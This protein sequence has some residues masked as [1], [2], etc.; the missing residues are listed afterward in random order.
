[1]KI[2]RGEKIGVVLSKTETQLFDKGNGQ[3]LRR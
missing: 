3:S 1:V 2:E